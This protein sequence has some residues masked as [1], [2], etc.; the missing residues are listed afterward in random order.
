MPMLSPDYGGGGLVNLVAELEARLR[1]SA[2]SPRLTHPLAEVDGWVLVL[3]DGL[4]AAQLVHPAA[5]SLAAARQA[6]LRAGFPT[7]TTTSLA[8]VA[9]GLPP[10][11]HGVIGHLMR[12]PD[13]AGVVNV[14][15]W[16]SPA[17]E[18]VDYDYASVLPSP[19]LWE[20]LAG[21]GVEAVTVQPGDFAATPLTRLLYRGCRFEGVWSL[22]EMAAATVELARPGRL[23]FT[24]FPEVD[25]AAH[26][27]G[28]ASDSYA[29]AL[30]RAGWLW[31]RLVASLPATIGLVGTADHGLVDYRDQD[32]ILIRHRRYDPLC[33][34]G[35][36]RSTYVDGPV[37]LIA[38]LGAATGARVVGETDL[39][40]LLGPHPRPD[41]GNRLPQRLLLAPP[42]RLLMARPFDRRLV[43]YHGGLEPAEVEVPLLARVNR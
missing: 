26:V 37:E 15:K 27:D 35:D 30:G 23:V 34:F 20:R 4:G 33:F 10:A 8:T 21:A 42:G 29:A 43:G 17:G 36:P 3:Y 11:G 2:P 1:G 39:R 14:L 18:P 19:N 32:K 28:Q 16:V 41:L 38:E 7:T 25:F 31:D 5:A 22:E 9:T 40:R 13:L 24:Y 12:F 6:I